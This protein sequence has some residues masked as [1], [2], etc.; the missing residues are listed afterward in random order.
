MLP[1]Q[2]L[3][4]FTTNYPLDSETRC[5]TINLCFAFICTETH[6]MT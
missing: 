4:I 6:L 1:A 5:P 2:N 3:E